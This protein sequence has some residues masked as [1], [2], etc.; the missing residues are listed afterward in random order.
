M[1]YLYETLLDECVLCLPACAAQGRA[2][3]EEQPAEDAEGEE[4]AAA[5]APVRGA[6]YD[7]L[8]S[9]AIYSLT[10]EKIQS[11]QAEA[12]TQ[13]ARVQY[14]LTTT[15]RQMWHDDLDAFLQVR[16]GR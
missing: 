5:A 12:D 9:M 4:G 7:Y 1:L 11:L 8:L 16:H 6:S 14:L 15:C 13:Q 3:G 10:E 2:P